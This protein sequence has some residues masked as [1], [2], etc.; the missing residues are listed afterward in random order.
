M[1]LDG[2][3]IIVKKE[4]I[5]YVLNKLYDAGYYWKFSINF[6]KDID[7]E[8]VLN[9]INNEWFN[10]Y[11]KIIIT[12]ESDKKLLGYSDLDAIKVDFY[13]ITELNIDVFYR[14]DKLKRILK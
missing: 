2:K 3:Y 13:N 9:M 11:G 5:N 12:S 6:G 8:E 10:I 14:E 7:R 4:Q 1:I